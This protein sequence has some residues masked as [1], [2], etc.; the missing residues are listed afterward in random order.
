MSAIPRY[1]IGGKEI[2]RCNAGAFAAWPVRQEGVQRPRVVGYFT[3]LAD[4]ESYVG[5][6]NHFE[7]MASDG[8]GNR[9]V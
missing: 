1:V 3:T 4:A 8:R 7:Q 5:M 2:L 9:V 6:A